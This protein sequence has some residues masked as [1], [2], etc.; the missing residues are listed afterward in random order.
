M[1]AFKQFSFDKELKA[2]WSYVSV[3][4]FICFLV[5]FSP[6]LG[7]TEEPIEQ[8]PQVK[9]DVQKEYD[10]DGNMT[11]YDSSWNWHWQGNSHFDIHHDSIWTRFNDHWNRVMYD[12]YSRDFFDSLNINQWADTMAFHFKDW[13]RSMENFMEEERY[14][15]SKETIEEWQ[16]QHQ[17]FM[18]SF[19]EYHMEHKKLLRKYFYEYQKEDMDGNEEPQMPPKPEKPKSEKN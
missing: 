19:K 3:L 12:I 8:K 5:M 1:K 11:G 2:L 9:I 4:S 10:E 6:V 14:K 15:P 16:K 13:G 17:E 18:E 7:Q